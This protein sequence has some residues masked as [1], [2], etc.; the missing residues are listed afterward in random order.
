MGPPVK[1]NLVLAIA[2]A[3]LVIVLAGV[4][5]YQK[6]GQ[7]KEASLDTPPPRAGAPDFGPETQFSKGGPPGVKGR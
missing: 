2:L 6:L 3:A 5:I 1:R 4:L 7:G